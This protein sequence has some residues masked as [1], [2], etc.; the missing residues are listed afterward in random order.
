MSDQNEFV[1]IYHPQCKASQKLLSTI[2]DDNQMVKLINVLSIS[3]LPSGLKSV[4]AGIVEDGIITGKKL[5]EKVASLLNGPVSVNIFGASNQ[6]GFINGPSNFNLNSNFTPLEG[7]GQAD[8]FTGVPKFDEN[9][10]KTIDQ[11]QTERT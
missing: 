4:P 3:K 6:A 9:Q 2:P 11:L 7:T 5:F 8:G 1:I 10:V